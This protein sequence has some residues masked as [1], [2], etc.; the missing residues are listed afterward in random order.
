MG[1]PEPVRQGLESL[2]TF[3]PYI[4]DKNG[5]RGVSRDTGNRGKNGV[6]TRGERALTLDGTPVKVWHVGVG[7]LGLNNGS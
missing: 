1:R 3:P 2:A 7:R 4:V 5:I 6:G